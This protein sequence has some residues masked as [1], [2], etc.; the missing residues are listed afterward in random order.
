VIYDQGG[1]L[2]L[3]REGE[4][5]VLAEGGWKPA[6]VRVLGSLPLLGCAWLMIEVFRGGGYPR[7]R[8]G[9]AYLP[10]VLL[11]AVLA[12]LFLVL[13]AAVAL[14][15][16]FV[17]SRFLLSA[18]EVRSRICVLGWTYRE[19]TRPMSAFR[20]VRRVYERRGAKGGSRGWTILLAGQE[21]DLELLRVFDRDRAAGL[22][23]ELAARC[24]LPLE[25][26]GEEA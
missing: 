23:A 7:P 16:L 24:G 2:I 18:S 22:G 19:R 9:P 6:G 11:L 26:A 12:G 20:A 1:N 15:M 8:P 3:R 21:G 13:P 4:I 14:H 25:S 17:R 10:G 5:L